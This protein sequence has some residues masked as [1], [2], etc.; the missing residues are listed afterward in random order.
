MYVFVYSAHM[1]VWCSMSGVVCARYLPVHQGELFSPVGKMAESV[2]AG[3]ITGT[4]ALQERKHVIHDF[5]QT[6]VPAQVM[7]SWRS[8]LHSKQNTNKQPVTHDEMLVLA[9]SWISSPLG[10]T[11]NILFK[12]MPTS[13]YENTS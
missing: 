3:E 10:L 7:H 11:V 13:L 12:G 8:G 5:T 4:G 9:C 6:R 2:T 1:C